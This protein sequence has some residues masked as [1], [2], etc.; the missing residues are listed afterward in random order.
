[1]KSNSKFFEIK[2]FNQ[3]KRNLKIYGKYLSF[4]LE[5]KQITGFKKSSRSDRKNLSKKR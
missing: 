5:T 2:D 4:H 1:M 3:M